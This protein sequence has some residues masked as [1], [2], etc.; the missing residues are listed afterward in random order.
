MMDAVD[1]KLTVP[2]KT[3]ISNLIDKYYES[4]VQKFRNRLA[5]ARRVSIG[6]DLWTKTGLTASFL[7]I[8]SCYF[9]VEQSKP[10]HI[11]LALEQVVHPHT[12]Q[13]IKAC[14]DKCMQEWGIP[15]QKI[16]TVITDNGSNMVAAFK[17]TTPEREETTSEDS[18][19]SPMMDSD[20]E[21]ET[22]G[23]LRC[24]HVDMDIERTPCVVHTLQ[25]VVHMIQKESGVK[26]V[27]DKARSV[28]KLFRKSSI[29]TQRLLDECGLIVV[30]DCPM[31]WSSTFNMISRLLKVKDSVCQ[32]A[33]NMGWDSL[34]PSEW[35]KLKSLHELLLPFAEHTQTLQSDTMS[36]SLVVPALFDL[37]SHLSDF[38]ENTTHRDLVAL[39]RKMKGSI[40]QR[41]AWILDP[42]DEKFSP[43]VA[44][45]CFV[46]PRVCETLVDV[47]DENIQELLKQAEEYVIQVTHPHS[48]HEDQ[49]KDDGE[50]NRRLPEEPEAAPSTSKQPVFRFLSK[51]HTKSVKRISTSSIRQQIRK[52]KE[53]LSQ[54]ITRDCDTGIDFWL[55]KSDTFYHSLKP[56]A[57]D[58]LAIPASQAFA[59]RVFSV[60][61]D[62]TRGRRNR[63]RVTLAR[64]AFLKM[65][66]NK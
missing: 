52:Y 35:Q 2:K 62:L 43:L 34:L 24:H 63:A 40:N 38:E 19:D 22:E 58:L 37:L 32:I 61:G 25:L 1:R 51:W 54:P 50:E 56:F 42:T 11:L 20:S 31:R 30:N 27:L 13:S 65:N 53:E 4:E 26:R 28:V 47:A 44:A 15:N 41:F 29:A 12:A 64:S 3:K 33:N 39:A 16:I 10:E 57:L 21:P 45:A 59:E 23:D 9:C 55:E 49:P 14:V 48:Q 6:I 66:R 60:T 18:E 8:S 7:A 36:M 17:Q 5:A 46:N